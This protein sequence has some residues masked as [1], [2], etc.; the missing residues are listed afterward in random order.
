[1]SEEEIHE[2][3]EDKKVTLL[4]PGL[5]ELEY[6]LFLR[7]KGNRSNRKF[8]MD[9]LSFYDKQLEFLLQLEKLRQLVDW[10]FDNDKDTAAQ[11]KG[12]MDAIIFM[13]KK[14]KENEK[15]IKEKLAEKVAKK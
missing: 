3:E 6:E 12:M 7:N 11:I 13:I 1:M 4:I 15:T 5:S 9:L 2:K 8:L 10:Y 14:K